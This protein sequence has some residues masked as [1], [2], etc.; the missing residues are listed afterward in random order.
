MIEIFF[1][2]I[3]A[4]IYLIFS[5]N[6]AAKLLHGSVRVNEAEKKLGIHLQIARY[7]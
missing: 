6:V 5:T 3:R 4:L 1:S 2:N 7:N